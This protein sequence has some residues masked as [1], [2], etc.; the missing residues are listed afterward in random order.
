MRLSIRT[1]LITIFVLLMA[2]MAVSMT[3]AV[4]GLGRLDQR[5]NQLVDQSAAQ[6]RASILATAWLNDSM[7]ELKNL[8]LAPDQAGWDEADKSFLAARA[9]FQKSIAICARWPTNRCER[10]SVRWIPSTLR[11]WSPRTR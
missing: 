7:R 4:V 1:K 3:V 6:V 5:I 10:C 8:L 9:G 11:R 2:F